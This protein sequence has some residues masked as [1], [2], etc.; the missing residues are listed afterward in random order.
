MFVPHGNTVVLA[1]LAHSTC[2]VDSSKSAIVNQED[3]THFACIAQPCQEGQLFNRSICPITGW[4]RPVY[5]RDA[6]PGPNPKLSRIVVQRFGSR[7]SR[8]P[9]TPIPSVILHTS[10]TPRVRLAILVVAKMATSPPFSAA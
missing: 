4:F 5:P 10:G 8:D 6:G 1:I 2:N 7:L 3:S 9:I